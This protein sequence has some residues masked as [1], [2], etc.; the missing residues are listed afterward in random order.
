MQIQPIN[1]TRCVRSNFGITSSAISQMRLHLFVFQI[2]NRI[3][4]HRFLLPAEACSP[5]SISTPLTN[6]STSC[7]LNDRYRLHTLC[8]VSLNCVA[9]VPMDSWSSSATFNLL[10]ISRSTFVL[11]GDQLPI[12][13][14]SGLRNCPANFSCAKISINFL[15]TKSL[16]ITSSHSKS[17]YSSFQGCS[18]FGF[19]SIDSFSARI[20]FNHFLGG[21]DS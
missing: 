1:A 8:A 6:S 13:D 18:S 5:L 10:A 21:A 20:F 12:C 4:A 16:P 17:P 9:A 19:N 11:Q 2:Q 14:S 15:E 3:C 7:A